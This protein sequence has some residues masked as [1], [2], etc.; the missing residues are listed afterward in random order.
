M[1]VWIL[2]AKNWIEIW[3]FYMKR[4]EFENLKTE[5]FE[6]GCVNI[7]SW[8]LKTKIWNLFVKCLEGIWKFENWNVWILKIKKLKIEMF[9][10]WKPKCLNIENWK[11]KIE[12]SEYWKLKTQMSE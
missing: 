3:I 10:Y 9:E 7:K 11:L 4:L 2:K 6:F 12:M 5:M 8:K 1:D